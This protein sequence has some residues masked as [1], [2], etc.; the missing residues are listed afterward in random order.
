VDGRTGDR[1]RRRG[2][3]RALSRAHGSVEKHRQ[4]QEKYDRYAD[5]GDYLGDEDE[6]EYLG[7]TVERLSTE[8]SFEAPFLEGT[9]VFELIGREFIYSRL[10]LLYV[11][12]PEQRVVD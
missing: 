3:V 1:S 10:Y 7:Q 5:Y 2:P 9:G 12:A 11:A 8:A 6:L 4:E